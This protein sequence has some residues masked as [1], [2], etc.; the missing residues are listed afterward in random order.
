MGRRPARVR[1][2]KLADQ[3]GT[4]SELAYSEIV[5][6]GVAEIV[7]LSAEAVRPGVAEIV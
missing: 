3:I 2:R 5:G 7:G 6:L 1:G 4:E